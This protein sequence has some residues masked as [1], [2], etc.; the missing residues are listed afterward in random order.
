MVGAEF[1][2]APKVAWY[3]LTYC[4]IGG[5]GVELWDQVELLV[6]TIKINVF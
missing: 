6:V 4:S 5:S 2:F 3:H 1:Y